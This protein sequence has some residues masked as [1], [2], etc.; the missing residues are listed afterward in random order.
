MFDFIRRNQVDYLTKALWILKRRSI[1]AI[2]ENNYAEV[3]YLADRM[4]TIH[5][6]IKELLIQLERRNK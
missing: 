3:E 5:K 1:E 2:Y 6:R 4:N